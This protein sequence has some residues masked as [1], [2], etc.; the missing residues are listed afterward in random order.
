MPLVSVIIPMRNAE[1]YVRAAVESVLAQ[2]DVEFEVIVVDD[3]STDRSAQIVRGIGDP[4]VRIIPGPQKGISA[5]F[6]T[7][8][9]DAKG[10]LLARCDADDLYPPDRLAWQAAFLAERPDFG[11]ISGGQSTMSSRGKLIMDHGTHATVASGGVDVTDELRAGRGRSHMCAYLFRTD[12]LR[13]LGGCREFFVTAEDV[14]LQLRLSEITRI[15]HDPRPAYLYRL[16][17]ASITH[18]Q[19]SGERSFFEQCAKR[20]QQQR[21]ERG[22]DDLQLG[23]PPAMPPRAEGT[24]AVST[25]NQIQGLLLGQAWAAHAS[26]AR[27][28]AM[29]LGVRAWIANPLSLA[30]LRSV[31]ALALKPSAKA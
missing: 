3:G 15:W 4:R 18:V 17:D 20:F 6:N 1:P 9:A 27:W 21:R 10:E 11:A 14:D 13:K 24:G 31:M 7:G 30:T 8:L 29:K 5:S 23:W 22:S 25:W 12:L 26:G 28:A 2:K 16:H 19:K